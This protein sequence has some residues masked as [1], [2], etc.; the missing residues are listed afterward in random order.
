MIGAEKRGGIYSGYKATHNYG[1]DQHPTER[2][3]AIHLL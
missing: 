2:D 3:L 1:H